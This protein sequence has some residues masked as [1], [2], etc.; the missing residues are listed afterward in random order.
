M[1]NR[2]PMCL[3]LSLKEALFWLWLHWPGI[4]LRQLNSSSKE[5]TLFRATLSCLEGKEFRAGEGTKEKRKGSFSPP[6]SV[7]RSGKN[8][9]KTGT[10]RLC[11]STS[12]SLPLTSGEK[13]LDE[14]TRSHPYHQNDQIH[15]ISSSTKG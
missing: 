2:A 7:S 10:K 14:T 6:S 5:G 4:I 11:V 15:L 13:D 1:V 12:V 8:H 3:S 9:S